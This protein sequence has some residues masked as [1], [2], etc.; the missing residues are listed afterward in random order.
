M[1]HPID[2]EATVRNGLLDVGIFAP[3]EMLSLHDGNE[4][5]QDLISA[6]EGIGI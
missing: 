2:I 4:L 5:M 6:L 1:Q 3:A